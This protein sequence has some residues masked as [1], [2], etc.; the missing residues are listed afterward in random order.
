MIYDFGSEHVQLNAFGRYLHKLM[1]T[2]PNYGLDILIKLLKDLQYI[3][4]SWIYVYNF[5]LIYLS[6]YIYLWLNLFTI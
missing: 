3:E 1:K 5:Y 6:L 4:W 2:F